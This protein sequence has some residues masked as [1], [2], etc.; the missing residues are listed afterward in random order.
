MLG[1]KGLKKL[2]VKITC[3]ERQPP[4]FSQKLRRTDINGELLLTTTTGNLASIEKLH[5]N[6]CSLK[7]IISFHT[8][9]SFIVHQIFE[10]TCNWSKHVTWLNIPSAKLGNKHDSLHLVKKY[11]Y[12]WTFLLR[13]YQ[14]KYEDKYRYSSTVYTSP[15][16]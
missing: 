16:P 4:E 11:M 9:S 15:I 7:N 14:I 8:L 6:C 2:H 13:H 1:S 5:L 12:A 3:T 10:L